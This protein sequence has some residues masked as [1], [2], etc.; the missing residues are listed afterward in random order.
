MEPGVKCV[1]GLSQIGKQTNKHLLELTDALVMRMTRPHVRQ[2][3]GDG[4][5]HGKPRTRLIS[6]AA[7]PVSSY[8]FRAQAGSSD[9]S[10][11]ASN[12]DV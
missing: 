3:S 1:R 7:T 8:R 4:G 6:R 10:R 2:M 12:L 5:D 11:Q 9:F